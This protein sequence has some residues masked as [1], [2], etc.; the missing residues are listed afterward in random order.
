[1]W[2]ASGFFIIHWLFKSRFLIIFDTNIQ[3]FVFTVKAFELI[4]IDKRKI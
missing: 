3:L 4:I 2:S 1:M